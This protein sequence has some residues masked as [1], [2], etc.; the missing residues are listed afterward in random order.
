MAE[1]KHTFKLLVEGNEDVHVIL[2][3]WNDANLPEVFDIKDCKSIDKL[4]KE[5]KLRLT[6]PQICQ[7]IG[8][9][10]D[11][12]VDISARWDAII[13]RLMET[14]KYDCKGLELP[15][16]GLVLQP[17]DSE[18]PTIGVW[19]MPN[20]KLPGMLEDFVATLSEPNDVLMMKADE[21]L[22]EL[23]QA[24]IQRYKSVHRAKAKIHSYLAWQDEPGKPMGTSITAHVL[25]PN[26]PSGVAFIDWLQRLFM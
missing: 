10:V 7:R 3:L 12:D 9:V 25:N 23:E 24:H 11:A 4:L 21:V 2:A 8:I 6:T 22:D 15:N 26:S 13:S 5:L 18:Y 20:N 19:V 1:E 17:M 14:G 16:D